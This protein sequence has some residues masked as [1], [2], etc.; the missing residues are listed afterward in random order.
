[1]G[2]IFEALIIAAIISHLALATETAFANYSR[3]TQGGSTASK[4]RMLFALSAH[5]FLLMMSIVCMMLSDVSDM[6]GMVIR[7]IA[8]ATAVI[9]IPIIFTL[10][11]RRLVDLLLSN[12]KEEVLG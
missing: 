9:C 8:L 12:D 5:A 6:A 3:R 4:R 11:L 10:Y 7:I 2:I 1:M